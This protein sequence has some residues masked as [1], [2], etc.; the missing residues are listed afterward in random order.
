MLKKKW[1]FW[2]IGGIVLFLLAVVFINRSRDYS[3]TY[4]VD[5]YTIIESYEGSQGLLNIEVKV[6]DIE[7]SMPML[8]ERLNK[9]KVIDEV[10][11]VQ[12]DD[13]KCVLLKS[14]KIDSY[15]VCFDGERYV[16]YALSG[17]ADDEFFVRES[18]RRR[19]STYEGIS[20]LSYPYEN[21]FVWNYKG[22]Y[23]LDENGAEG[24]DFLEKES[25]YN[26]LAYGV[27][28]FL[29]TPNYDEE[30]AFTEFFIIN[31]KKSKK[32][33]WKFKGEI[34]F[35]SYFLGEK[36]G[37]VYMV[38]RKN[39]AEYEI[40]VKRKK[41][42]RIDKNGMGRVWNGKWT[43]VSMAKLVDED[44]VF[45]NEA[46]VQYTTED[47]VLVRLET[48]DKRRTV[49]SDKKVDKIVDVDG[50][51]VYYLVKDELYFYSPIF[52]ENIVLKWS[53][54]D[55]NSTNAVFIY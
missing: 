15:P 11:I 13:K 40:D 8:I 55:F 46:K 42:E 50:D 6:D 43:E 49:L 31:M 22:Y 10:K 12:E 24:I 39:K 29:L 16:D 18:L 44:Y 52:G 20:L 26:N 30:Y 19:D 4:E 7:F 5:G 37:L 41:L 2:A 21:C 54:L 53:E 34:S 28:E 36:D 48:E 45:E 38:D 33:S 9:K 27:D 1:M 32:S 17:L 14:D 51:E 23:R 47:K 3:E 25:Y 35:N